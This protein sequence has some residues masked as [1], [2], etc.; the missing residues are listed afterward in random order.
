MNLILSASKQAIEAAR[1]G[2][3]AKAKWAA[4]T[5][6]NGGLAL[7]GASRIAPKAIR[8]TR[9]DGSEVVF[10]TTSSGTVQF[11]RL[12]EEIREA[13]CAGKRILIKD[14]RVEAADALADG[15]MIDLA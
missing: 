7:L 2:D 14:A 3:A 5:I 13:L 6:H 10:S 11:D 1:S 15:E 8:A 9:K 4:A 12:P